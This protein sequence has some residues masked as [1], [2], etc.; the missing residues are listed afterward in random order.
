MVNY[1][2]IKD[3]GC[4]MKFS[5]KYQ[6]SRKQI[7]KASASKSFRARLNSSI[8]SLKLKDV[9]SEEELTKLHKNYLPK[10]SNFTDFKNAIA[11]DV[12]SYNFLR[13]VTQYGVETNAKNAM[14]IIKTI[15][16]TSIDDIKETLSPIINFDKF[17]SLI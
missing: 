9:F 12:I 14:Q 10:F 11:E 4:K 6:P 8:S 13:Y 17:E 5:S 2:N 16:H 3:G 7:E 1:G 15:D